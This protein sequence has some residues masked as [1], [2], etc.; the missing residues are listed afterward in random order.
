MRWVFSKQ[1]GYL[2]NGEGSTSG[3]NATKIDKLNEKLSTSKQK[4]DT[5]LSLLVERF[6]N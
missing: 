4:Y 2:Y 5:L 3:E 1:N 6:L